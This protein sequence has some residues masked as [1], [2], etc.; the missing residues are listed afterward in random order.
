MWK[1]QDLVLNDGLLYYILKIKKYLGVEMKKLLLNLLFPTKRDIQFLGEV[2]SP[3]LF[4]KGIVSSA[5][6]YSETIFGPIGSDERRKNFGYIDLHIKVMHPLLFITL[7]SLSTFYKD[8]LHSKQYASFD[9]S[10]KDFVLSTPD[11][12]E[13]GYAFFLKYLDKIEFK[14]NDSVERTE[15]IKLLNKHR[16][17]YGYT[18]LYVYPAGLRDF[19][20]DK[21]GKLKENEMTDF[22][23]DIVNLSKITKTFKGADASA[24]DTVS[25][26]MQTLVTELYSHILSLVDGK[27]K[28]IN[29]QFAS[30]KVDYATQNVLVGLPN[31][32]KRFDKAPSVLNMKTGIFQ[33]IKM[34]DPKVKEKFRSDWINPL[35]DEQRMRLINTKTKESISVELSNSSYDLIATEDG[36]DKLFNM[37]GVDKKKERAFTIDGYYVYLVQDTGTEVTIY[38]DLTYAPEVVKINT[39]RPITLAEIFYLIADDL[40]KEHPVLTK[41]YPITG[42]QSI[43]PMYVDITPTINTRSVQVNIVDVETISSVKDNYIDFKSEWLDAVAVNVSTEEGYG[44]DRDGDK[45]GSIGTFSEN[46]KQEIDSL[47][48]SLAYWIDADGKPTHNIDTIPIKY[49]ALSLTK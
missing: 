35:L 10:D 23:R 13:T 28:F 31:K 20:T 33:Y 30:T 17:K 3:Q 15:K 16:D 24:L 48:G 4:D 29:K 37:F 42:G 14:E 7:S 45:L 25:I 43:R 6:L 8:I 47:F 12:G 1:K 21:N 9:E 46:S 49:T 18:Y 22:Y 32:P 11:E 5:G 34:L 41:R 39:L 40:S 2:T 26:R 36:L 38:K 44:A 19:I 27:H